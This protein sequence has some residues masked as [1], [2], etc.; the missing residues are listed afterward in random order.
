MSWVY[1][2]NGSVPPPVPVDDVT[3]I[4]RADDV[5]GDGS[6]YQMLLDPTHSLYGTT[7]P[8]EGPLSMSCTGNEGIYN[9]FE[10]KIPENADGNCSTQ[11]I[12]VNNSVTITIPAGAYDWCIANPTPN[13]RIWIA[14]SDGNIGGRYD[15]F[16]FEASVDRKSVV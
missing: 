7:I 12:V 4:L 1:F 11:N 5:W 14:S 15:D 13:D 6:G 16:E 3:V 9:Q 8:T 10:Y 2:G